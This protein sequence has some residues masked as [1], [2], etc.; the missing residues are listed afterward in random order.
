MAWR[1][2]LMI[3]IL[4]LL[5]CAPEANG[6][7][8]GTAPAPQEAAPMAPLRWRAVLV[9]GDASLPVW[10]NAVQRLLTGLQT[11]QAKLQRVAA[12][13]QSRNLLRDGGQAGVGWRAGQAQRRLGGFNPGADGRDRHRRPRRARQQRVDVCQNAGPASVRGQ[14]VG[15]E[16]GGHRQA[17]LARSVGRGI[18]TPQKCTPAACS[19]R[20]CSQRSKTA[21]WPAQPGQKTRAP[22]R[23]CCAKSAGVSG[24]GRAAGIETGRWNMSVQLS[25]GFNPKHLLT[26]GL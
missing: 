3:A 16:I 22:G 5:A 4:A 25:T 23:K 10:D 12:L 7:K 9:A 21:E 17:A 18:H 13:N 1:S 15:T 6:Q 26:R 11:A 8:P 20:A 14:H 19:G 2:S 24:L